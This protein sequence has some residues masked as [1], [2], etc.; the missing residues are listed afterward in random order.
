[1][2]KT[3]T[4]ILLILLITSCS[5][6]NDVDDGKEGI[7]QVPEEQETVEI[8]KIDVWDVQPVLEF[9]D[10]ENWLTT[11][12]SLYSGSLAE[13]MNG[14]YA[15]PSDIFSVSYNRDDFYNSEGKDLFITGSFEKG[16]LMVKK[17]GKWGLI[18]SK[19]ETKT[20]CE[21]NYITR[22]FMGVRYTGGRINHDYTLDGVKYEAGGGDGAGSSLL[23][24]D[25]NGNI[26]NSED[27]NDEDSWFEID[28]SFSK[29]DLFEEAKKS[30]YVEDNDFLVFNSYPGIIDHEVYF[31]EIKLPA[32]CLEGYFVIDK[33]GFKML[34]APSNYVI[35]DVSDDIISFA[36]CTT[37]PRNNKLFGYN[38]PNPLTMYYY[39]YELYCDKYNYKNYTFIDRDGNIIARGFDDAYG[40]YDGYAAVKKN[41]KWGFIDKQGNLAVDFMFDKATALSEGK[42]WVIYNGK[43]GRLNLVEL[44]E[45]GI[46][47][48]SDVLNSREITVG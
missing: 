35:N 17:N 11:K 2:K 48:N 37:D 15:K 12:K 21:N 34:D 5:N 1:M 8:Q 13:G 40:F 4:I 7:N 27:E 44:L 26:Y 45:N 14:G 18:N 20:E 47:I 36:E 23:F 28:N 41:G 43:T 3:L 25:V 30:G 6:N 10:I 32:N 31:P 42:S 24:I 16:G 33:N 9:D 39:Y 29:V 22:L 38:Q 19:G 46:T